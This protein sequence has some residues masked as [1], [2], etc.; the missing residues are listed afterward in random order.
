MTPELKKVLEKA[1]NQK[2]EYK[3][4]LDKL[5][6]KPPRNL[7]DLVHRAHDEAF[8]ATDCLACANCCKTTSPI[9]R[10]VDIERL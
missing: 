4:L 6:K 7:D 8:K 2:A 3:M 9:F 5:G 10:M 1:K